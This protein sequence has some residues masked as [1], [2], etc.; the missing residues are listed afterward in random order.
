M[1]RSL[2]ETLT[3]GF[4]CGFVSYTV[5]RGTI[6]DG[7][8]DFFFLRIQWFNFFGP[9]FRFIHELLSCPY[10]FSHWVAFFMVYMWRPILTN[11]GIYALDFGISVFLIVG[12]SSLS[13]AVFEKMRG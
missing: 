5:T 8:R 11:C 1:E 4:A 2:I 6:F 10:C 9:M 7:I 3:L 12:I 13:W